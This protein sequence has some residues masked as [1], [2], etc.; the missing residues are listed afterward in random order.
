MNRRQ[1]SGLLPAEHLPI[2]MDVLLLKGQP[3]PLQPLQHGPDPVKERPDLPRLSH[4]D[5]LHINEMANKVTEQTG[6]LTRIAA[7]QASLLN[8]TIRSVKLHD[9]ILNNLVTLNNVAVLAINATNEYSAQMRMFGMILGRIR[10][11]IHNFV[12]AW[13]MATLQHKHGPVSVNHAIPISAVR[14]STV[15]G[16]VAVPRQP[17]QH[18]GPAIEVHSISPCI[19]ETTPDKKRC[20]N[21]GVSC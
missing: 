3:G 7:V 16:T 6:K 5:N 8:D 21:V 15:G 19:Y 9:I 14:G 20:I 10:T 12:Q 11:E 13:T 1:A 2:P 4:K 17:D 18:D